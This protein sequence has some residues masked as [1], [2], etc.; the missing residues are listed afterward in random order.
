MKFISSKNVKLFILLFACFVF[1]TGFSFKAGSL[2]QKGN[3]TDW[4]KEP[5]KALEYFLESLKIEP[6]NPKALRAAGRLYYKKNNY[7][8]AEEYL[9][10]AIKIDDK[11][12]LAWNNL[13]WLCLKRKRYQEMRDA[14]ENAIKYKSHKAT[15]GDR[16][17]DIIGIGIAYYKTND[18]VQAERF[19]SK[20]VKKKDYKYKKANI[21]A[22]FWMGF[23]YL[24]KGYNQDA[25]RSFNKFVDRKK[26]K[27]EA[28]RIVGWNL[29]LEGRYELAEKYLQKA[30]EIDNKHLKAWSNLGWLY[31]KRERYKEMHDAFEKAI[32]YGDKR[33]PWDEIGLGEAYYFLKDYSQARQHFLK[34]R[35]MKD[36]DDSLWRAK[37]M[38]GYTYIAQ[39]NYSKAYEIIGKEN[40]IGIKTQTVKDGIKVRQV[41]N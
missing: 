3:S 31:E 30:V 6:D 22:T 41:L 21:E 1:A 4:D 25:I 7:V 20:V 27:H 34:A 32:Q 2:R 36:S 29:Y 16:I 8:K 38:H 39:G 12:S 10:K 13:G 17:W 15:Q 19:F 28:N 37:Y 23:I 11:Y 35:E 40:I 33:N 18:I 24:E 14:F 26:E 5:D 9:K